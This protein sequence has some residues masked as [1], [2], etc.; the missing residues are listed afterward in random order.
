MTDT[1]PKNI[2]HIDALE[3]RRLQG[4]GSYIARC[5]E[6][7][8]NGKDKTGNHLRVW[9]DGKF[10]CIVDDSKE[11]RSNIL[12][13]A[14]T[15]PSG[16][17][18][19]GPT[20][21]IQPIV[22]IDETWDLEILKGLIKQYDYWLDR[23]VSYEICEKFYIGVATKGQMNKRIVIP[24]LNKQKTRIIGF[25]GRKL[26]KESDR[27]KWKHLGSSKKFIFPHQEKEIHSANSIILVEGPADVLTLETHNIK[28][29]VCLFGTNL[30]SSLLGYIL[31]LNPNKIFIATNNEPDN[32]SIGLK[33]AEKIKKNLL[34]FFGEDKILIA[35]PTKKDFNDMSESEVKDWAK[36]YL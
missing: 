21:N 36:I 1:K 6:C 34:Q 23:G 32:Q 30:S 12:N 11:H 20:K 24:I 15:Q 28:N 7:S 16:E 2:I 8:R 26:E 5:P 10:H 17:I 27:V 13:L 18:I 31:S 19:D 29:S 35:L 22:E 33:A 4:D 9:S 25:T 14:G 3:N